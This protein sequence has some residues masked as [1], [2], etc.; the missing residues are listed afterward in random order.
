MYKIIICLFIV[1]LSYSCNK[2]MTEVKFKYPIS[3]KSIL[4]KKIKV[5]EL[6]F[7]PAKIGID[8]NLNIFLGLYS[9]NVYQYDMNGKYIRNICKRGE[10]PGEVMNLGSLYAKN[11]K[12]YVNDWGGE[13]EIFDIKTGKNLESIRYNIDADQIRV[14]SKEEIF[15][16]KSKLNNKTLVREDYL[17]LLNKENNKWK[18]S[19]LSPKYKNEYFRMKIINNKKKLVFTPFFKSLYSFLAND[20]IYWSYGDEYKIYTYENKKTKL[21]L[22]SNID[23]IEYKSNMYEILKNRYYSASRKKFLER[24]VLNKPKHIPYFSHFLVSSKLG[25]LVISNFKALDKKTVQIDHFDINSKYLSS[26][27]IP[28][29]WGCESGMFALSDLRNNYFVY[30]VEDDD[31]GN[32]FLHIEKL[33]IK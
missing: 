22:K 31:T 20:Q 32:I 5:L 2:D 14:N 30:V 28:R 11:N 4:R 27:S 33:E 29:F 6:D 18:I 13:L 25:F 1:L 17:G 9:D 19:R 24:R 7:L 3:E 21:S 15:L 8:K 10:G 23:P 26:F 12:L 16:I